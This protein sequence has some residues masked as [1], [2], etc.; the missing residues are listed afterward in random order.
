MPQ[1]LSSHGLCLLY[2]PSYARRRL[3]AV[4]SSIGIEGYSQ[5]VA[6]MLP[7]SIG[8]TGHQFEIAVLN[9]RQ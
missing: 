2:I 3:N 7:G 4:P 1:K 5:V 9:P 8:C 6:I